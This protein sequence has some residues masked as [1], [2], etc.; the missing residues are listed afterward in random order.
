MSHGA[1][2]A[3][4][5][6]AAA[7]ESLHV[8]ALFGAWAGTVLDA[9]KV[10]P[11][12]RVA[13]VACGTG[14]LA[15]GAHARV[16]ADGCVVGVDPDA[17]MLTVAAREAPGV[18][19]RMGS[20][21]ALPLDDASQDAVVSQF[22]MM[23]F[24]D[25]DRAAAE[26]LRVLAAGGHLAVA[27]WDALERSPAYSALVTLLEDRAGSDAADAL[28]APF[29]LGDAHAFAL[30]FRRAGVEALKLATHS[31][32]ARFP[33]LRTM[34]EADLRGWLPVMGVVLDE[35]LIEEILAAAEHALARFVDARGRM[36]FPCSAHILSGVKG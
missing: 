8:P 1:P 16:G 9:A 10:G 4:V 11:G 30:P 32:T 24:R 14:I 2:A 36:V 7:Y 12:E 35:E 23:F 13:D 20:A 26:M 18:D 15:R 33:D 31:G 19:W 5:T 27:V 28:R 34:V 25:R 29:A 6:A 22:G 21:E 17:G 3:A